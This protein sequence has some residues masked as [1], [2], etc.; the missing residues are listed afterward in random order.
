MILDNMLPKVGLEMGGRWIREPNNDV[1]VVFVHGFN[2]SEKCWKSRKTGTIWPTL[3]VEEEKISLAGIYLFSYQTGLLSGSYNLGDIIDS[4]KELL[5]LDRVISSKTIIFVCHSMGGIIARQFVVINESN[6]FDGEAN[7]RIGFFLLASPSLGSEYANRVEILSKMLGNTQVD[8]LKF[9][10]TN[11][12]LIDLDK[13]FL[14]LKERR[15]SQIYG[16]ELIEDKSTLFGGFFGKPIVQRYSAAK[17]FGDPFKVPKSNHSTIAAPN[18]KDAIQ[19]R[20]LCQFV[21]ELSEKDDANPMES[22]NGS[23]RHVFAQFILLPIA[24]A[25]VLAIIIVLNFVLGSNFP[26]QE[27]I[28]ILAVIHLISNYI[29][30]LKFNWN[31]ALLFALLAAS[32]FVSTTIPLSLMIDLPTNFFLKSKFAEKHF[33]VL[34]SVGGSNRDFEIIYSFLG[35]ISMIS[36]AIALCWILYNLASSNFSL[37]GIPE[38][39]GHLFQRVNWFIGIMCYISVCYAK[40][41]IFFRSK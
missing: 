8:A 5:R 37:I 25:I 24:I 14:S 3:L 40:A 10:Q 2:S 11:S 7:R 22:E 26:P 33:S 1:S 29:A 13:N 23:I 38:N 18:G 31:N 15:N 9:S 36:L 39:Y 30:E 41:I 12:W 20:L 6:I 32:M 35:R 19:H 21:E 34:S 16:K 4:L 27:A 17:Y 28:D